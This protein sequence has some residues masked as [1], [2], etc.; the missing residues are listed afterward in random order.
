[1]IESP[2]SQGLAAT[3]PA[4]VAYLRD[5]TAV[6]GGSSGSVLS[7]VA[8]GSAATGGYEVDTSDID[9]LVVLADGVDNAERD[10]V[11]SVVAE[12]EA[13]HDLVK[14]RPSGRGKVAAALNRFADR[15]SDNGRSFFVCTR[16]DLLSGEARRI[17]NLPW[18][19]AVFVDRVVVPSMVA[20]AITVWG[21]D[22]LDHVDFQSIGRVDVAKSCFALFTQCTFAAAVYAVFPHVT[23]YA[24]DALKRSIHNCY[25][26]H[27]AQSAPLRLEVAYFERRYGW[28]AAFTQLL[29]LRQQYRPS[30]RF[31]I[32][33][34]SAVLELHLII[35]PP[36]T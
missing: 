27:S 22:L 36:S 21:D 4:V 26:C 9:L 2:Q 1:M 19:Q 14:A 7:L 13:Q 24:M 30:F 28:R 6:C 33:S 32:R 23:T 3:P 29:A 31:A 8:F 10:R 12:L 34:L 11:R 17:L 35:G 18:P 20:S 5:V 25:Y 16:A 15:T